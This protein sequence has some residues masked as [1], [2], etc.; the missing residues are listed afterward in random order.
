VIG[1]DVGGTFT[2]VV[3]WRDGRL[4][5]TK[6]PSVPDDPQQ[7]V[8]EG[9]RRLGVDSATIFNHASTKGLNAVLTRRLPKVGFLTTDGH[10]DML[11]AGRAW[12]PFEG[13]L[14][15]R[16]RR[17]FGDAAR[18]LVPRYL[19]R[20][21]RERILASGEVLQSLDEADARRQ[22]EL[23]KRCGVE[24]VAI[25]LLNAYVEP[26][27]ERRL[28]E[29]AREVLGELPVSASSDTSPRA[30]EF[31]RAVTTV[32][33]VMMKLMYADYAA[34]L[35]AGLA[36]LGFAGELNF[37]DCSAAL[38]PWRDAL[39]HPFR[40]L[41][42]GPA[43]GAASCRELGRALGEADLI[44]CDVGGTS[45]DV[46]LIVAGES[47]TNDGFEIEHD[48]T[49]SAL[50]TEVASVGAG[51][52]S[53]VSISASGDVVVGP[54]SGGARPGAA[55]Y[56]RGAT[57][58]TVTDACLLMGILD[59]RGFAGGQMELDADAAR[60]AFAALDTPLPLEQ[61]VAQA[62]RIAVNN[63]AEEVANITIRHGADPRDFSL[64]AYGA[65]GPMLL[66]S[67]LEPLSLRRVIVPPHPGLFSAL[68]LLSAD[69]VHADSCSA[70]LPLAGVAAPRIAALYADMERRLLARLPAAARGAAALRRSF[71]ARIAGQSWE[72]AFIEVPPGAIDARYVEAMV[73]AF[74]AEYERRN[75]QHFR[76]MPV[77]GVNW[78]L[79]LVQ[80]AERFRHAPLTAAAGT[81]PLRPPPARGYRTLRYLAPQPVE[82]AIHEREALRPGMC[83]PGPAVIHEALCT[84][85]VPPGLAATVGR[86]GEL[87]IAAA[88]ETSR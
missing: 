66:P 53:I 61:R 37:A 82:A 60:R 39:E 62:Y 2:D 88:A 11:D 26:R 38:L 46:S 42:A 23:L 65:A 54:E 64:V 12:R 25:C 59:P 41:F 68:G 33:D 5:V 8:L 16:W 56:G 78:R 36:A 40:I 10:R 3:C 22:L 32:V 29:L 30:R 50:S 28:A 44:C 84:T 51:G 14:D 70:Y 58:P 86:F 35:H 55:C 63:I 21:V 81:P 20:G 18:P 6:V 76:G 87:S 52:G 47:F 69:L 72:T 85:L 31:T 79:Q 83:V 73:E 57:R 19:R 24:G 27:H 7:A 80:P 17:P 71:D 43:A 77:Q 15:A 34:H 9:A 1:V 13:Q 75:G 4:T 49:I 45:T 67:A 48:L 74:H